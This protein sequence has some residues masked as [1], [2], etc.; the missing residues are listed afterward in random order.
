MVQISM[1]VW[2]CA[3]KSS[4]GLE[5][6][7][8]AL[9]LASTRDRRSTAADQP[10]PPTSWC[11]LFVSYQHLPR[12]YPSNVLVT[13]INK[14]GTA[15]WPPKRPRSFPHAGVMLWL[16]R[17]DLR[18]HRHAKALCCGRCLQCRCPTK[19]R[20]KYLHQSQHRKLSHRP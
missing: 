7:L 10:R 15:S 17:S 13:N 8:V 6:P 4:C 9:V 20:P 18:P 1:R 19:T 5:G 2:R 3:L 16:S 14:P 12:V 11:E